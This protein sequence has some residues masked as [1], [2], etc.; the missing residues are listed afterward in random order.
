MTELVEAAATDEEREA[1]GFRKWPV[2]GEQMY[3]VTYQTHIGGVAALDVL[4]ATGDDAALE[5]QKQN[6]GCKIISIAPAPAQR[7]TLGVKAA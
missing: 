4:A 1:L 3:R 2:S 5:A 7:K 6:G